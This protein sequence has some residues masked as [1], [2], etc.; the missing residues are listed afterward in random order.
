MNVFSELLHLLILEVL[1]K[2]WSYE[3]DY[4]LSDRIKNTLAK[5]TENTYKNVSVHKLEGSNGYLIKYHRNNALE[6]HHAD[7]EGNSGDSA[8]IVRS[9]INPRFYSTMVHHYKEEL[10]KGNPICITTTHQKLADHFH[11]LTQRLVRNK[12]N[13]VVSHKDETIRGALHHSINVT[14]KPSPI[15]EEMKDALR[16]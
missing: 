13:L 5:D 4:E 10:D 2:P 14:N 9:K 7:I 16:K 11:R 3:K 6:V 12:P 15:Q 1:D 8:P